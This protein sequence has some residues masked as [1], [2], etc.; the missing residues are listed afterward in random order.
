MNQRKDLI[1]RAFGGAAD[2]YAQTAKLQRVTAGELAGRIVEIPLPSSPRVLEIGCGTG[3]LT[4]ALRENLAGA[5]W[6]VTDIS[7]DMLDACRRELG[8]PADI[9][10]LQMDGEATTIEGPFDL[11]CAN[12][13]FQ[14]FED[15]PASIAR[16]VSLL[17]PGGHLAYTTLAEGSLAEW[18][19]A[20]RAC[21]FVQGTPDFPSAEILNGCWPQVF[22]AGHVDVVETSQ[23]YPSALNFA[24]AIKGIGAEIPA[25][26]HQPLS[27]AALRSVLRF[28]DQ[29]DEVGMTYQVAYASYQRSS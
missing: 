15:L 21:G 1:N 4:E 5:R 24:R 18:R 20:H 17:S 26:D 12:M 16:L 28:L 10:F 29:G 2:S 13:T 8:D 23:S 7:H 19:E 14:W 27:A 11:I 25:A 22:G 3:F 9:Q 6:T